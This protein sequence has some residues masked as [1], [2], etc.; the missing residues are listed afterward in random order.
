M[1]VLYLAITLIIFL[2][3]IYFGL[4]LANDI[5]HPVLQT[6]FWIL[7]GATVL[8]IS[9]IIATTLFYNVLREK[10]GP[11]GDRGAIGEKGDDGNAGYCDPDCKGKACDII[12]KKNL[13]EYYSKLIA[14]SLGKDFDQNEKNEAEIRN[15]NI[16]KRIKLICHSNAFRE[17][18]KVK[19]PKTIIEYITTIYKKWIKLLV[20]SDQSTD[21]G[22]I[23]EYIETDG[24]DEEPEL[25]YH[26]GKNPFREIEKYDIYYWGSDLIFHPHVIQYCGEP[27][28]YKQMPQKSPPRLKAIRT[29]FYKWL[30]GN[31]YGGYM[32]MSI[33]KI[34]P[35]N[36]AGEKYYPLGHVIDTQ[37]YTKTG[38]KFIERYGIPDQ[39]KDRNDFSDKFKGD[40][41]KFGSILVLGSEKYL[42]P[43]KD[44]E[45]IWRNKYGPRITIWKPKDFYDHTYQKWFR[46]LGFLAVN[47]WDDK[48][49]RYQYG[50]Q[51]PEAQPIRLVSDELLI[52]VSD[53]GFKKMWDSNGSG[54]NHYASMW[55]PNDRFYL[56]NQNIPVVNRG[57]SKG[58][59]IK[60]YK[61]NPEAF[62]MPEMKPPIFEHELTTEKGVG[63]GYHGTPHRKPKYSIFSWLEMPLDVQVT[64]IGTGV[65]VFITHTTLNQVNSYFVKRLKEGQDKITGAFGVR[66]D[67]DIVSD[68]YKANPNNP[69]MIWRIICLNED[70][71][72]DTKC[73]KN[74]NYLIYSDYVKKFLKVEM[75]E[76][77]LGIPDFK[78]AK[79]PDP[80][81]PFYKELIKE[82]VWF[83]PKSAT[84]A[85]LA[86]KN[87]YK[88]RKLNN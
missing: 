13:N 49:P 21:K 76:K 43:P 23:R 11:P 84:G 2:G 68:N 64:N 15:S 26:K 59:T 66:R 40:G 71:K 12:I 6:F 48:N 42:Q 34:G 67:S 75:T 73:G 62:L 30:Y 44:W 41:P 16:L 51:N 18:S 52:D 5:Y 20:D 69:N 33:Y 31:K 86:M 74:T 53:T 65:K 56:A 77:A 17:V 27:R 10:R 19:T 82:F 63:I 29:N 46:A 35:Y 28:V 8:T 38:N 24:L 55:L 36:Y 47:N 79:L 72:I 4:Q 1:F 54:A 39:D 58:R 14:E 3:I 87:S 81:K 50:Y 25:S 70:G 78:L 9:N 57:F 22:Q 88:K 45:F 32:P 61:I 80:K 37:F 85:S 60:A 7:Y 83:N